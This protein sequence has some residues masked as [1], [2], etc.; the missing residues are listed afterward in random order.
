M[1]EQDQKQ[2]IS[3]HELSSILGIT[4]RSASRILAKLLDL[5]IISLTENGEHD[6]SVRQGRPTHYYIFNG[7]E[8]RNALM[9]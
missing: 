8:F 9:Q 7:L 4:A 3:S 1:F 2:I 6:R 5:N